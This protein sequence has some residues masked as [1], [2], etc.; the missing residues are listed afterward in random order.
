LKLVLWIFEQYLK[1][2]NLKAH[3]LVLNVNAKTKRS[4]KGNYYCHCGCQD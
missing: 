2:Y 4:E 1:P 3:K